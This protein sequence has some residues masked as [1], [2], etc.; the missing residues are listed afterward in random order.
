M[1]CSFQCINPVLIKY[2]ISFD[3]IVNEIVFLILKLFISV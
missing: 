2:F 1:F 3:V